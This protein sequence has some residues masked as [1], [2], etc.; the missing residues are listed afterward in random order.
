MSGIVRVKSSVAR[1]VPNAGNDRALVPNH[2]GLGAAFHSFTYTD[3]ASPTQTPG[4][5]NM[6][7]A[8]G[9][10]I[11]RCNRLTLEGG[12]VS[13][14]MSVLGA[15]DTVTIGTQ[16]GTLNGPPSK[17]GDVWALSFTVAPGFPV[18]PNGTYQVSSSLGAAPGATVPVC[19][20]N[21]QASGSAK[22]GGVLNCT[23]G[24]WRGTIPITYAYQWTRDGVDIALA[25]AA[26]Y[27]VIALDLT[28]QIGCRV[29]ATNG[30]G[31]TSALSNKI[32]P[33]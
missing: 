19:S 31:S 3:G 1:L 29:K 27:T 30:A 17:N 7:Q 32:Y 6:T 33:V 4:P 8:T 12:D 13:A 14:A 26:D 5:G 23:P 24:T 20:I 11:V 10:L 2:P 28:K 22:L 25:T 16:T 21:P 9:S 18:L 15:G